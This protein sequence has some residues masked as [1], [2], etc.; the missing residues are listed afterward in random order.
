MNENRRIIRLWQGYVTN[1]PSEPNISIISQANFSSDKIF[2]P[3][4]RHIRRRAGVNLN[5][6]V[7]SGQ[8]M[9]HVN[10]SRFRVKP[11]IM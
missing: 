7:Y 10:W 8:Q 11:R 4:C 5:K 3:A 1:T 2:I 6:L 9:A